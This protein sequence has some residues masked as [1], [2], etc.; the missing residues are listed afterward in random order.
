MATF[1]IIKLKDIS[2]LHIG[3]GKENYDFA[4]SKLHSDTIS[5][6]LA[7]TRATQG[8]R[9]DIDKF[10]DSFTISSAFPYI[11][12]QYFLPRPIGNLN[13]EITDCENHEVRKQLKG[14]EY[15]EHGLWSELINGRKISINRNLISNK[16]IA[17]DNY[18]PTPYKSIVTQRVAVPR[19]AD[20]AEP[21]FFNWDFY[22]QDAGLYFITDASGNTLEEIISLFTLLGENGIGTDKNIG[23]GKFNIEV[24]SI[25]LPDVSSPNAQML[26]SLYIP[27]EDELDSIELHSSKYELLLR[28]GYISGSE[29]FDFWHL[30]KRSIY[31]FNVGSVI[32][33]NI[34]LM[35]KIVD[36]QPTNYNDERMHP[37]YRSG[38][39]FTLPINYTIS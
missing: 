22:N 25:T 21:F 10:L 30:R 12:N 39:P 14:I 8:N 27:T 26:L 31:M 5:A 15:I 4:A 34:N 3:T 33:T 29:Q 20:D 32:M 38:K 24:D 28:S 36:L 16:F 18:L 6:A 11:G 1:S 23:G 2:P 9:D 19:N 13:I 7:A 37:V 35:G 17:N